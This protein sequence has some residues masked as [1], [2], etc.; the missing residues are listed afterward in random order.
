[1]SVLAF[2]LQTLFHQFVD[3]LCWRC[4]TNRLKNEFLRITAGILNSIMGHGLPPRWF[5]CIYEG[6]V[7]SSTADCTTNC[8]LKKFTLILTLGHCDGLVGGVVLEI[9]LT[10]LDPLEL[11]LFL[12]SHILLK[13]KAAGKFCMFSCCWEYFLAPSLWSRSKSTETSCGLTVWRLLAT[14]SGRICEIF[15]HSRGLLRPL[16]SVIYSSLLT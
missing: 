2:S 16:P 8:S 10:L 7:F 11:S 12:I 9:L 5:S 4:R 13:Y 1:M 14:C 3:V 15:K 6:S